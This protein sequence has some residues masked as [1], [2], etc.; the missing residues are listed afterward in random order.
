MILIHFIE[1]LFKHG[2]IDDPKHPAS[3]SIAVSDENV[4]IE[5]HNRINTA[6]QY[7]DTGIGTANIIA[8]LDLLFP[9]GYHLHAAPDGEQYR[10]YLKFPIHV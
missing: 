2:I 7:T 10:A 9:A 8:R 5:T 3:I 6:E 1:N 4:S